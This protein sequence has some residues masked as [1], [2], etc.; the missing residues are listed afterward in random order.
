MEKFKLSD[1]Q[2]EN[3]AGQID[4]VAKTA[5]DLELVPGKGKETIKELKSLKRQLEKLKKETDP[6]IFKYRLEIRREIA[7]KLDAKFVG[8]FH[9]GVAVVEKSD[10][11][12]T[13][14]DMNGEPLVARWG[15]GKFEFPD[16]YDLEVFSKGFGRVKKNK[17]KDVY[18]F[19]FNK[20]GEELVR[21]NNLS[22]VKGDFSDGLIA[23]QKE[24]TNSFIFL[25]KKGEK[26]EFSNSYGNMFFKDVKSF[27]KGLAWVQAE[28]KITGGPLN[29]GKWYLIN[30]NGEKILKEGFSDVQNFSDGVAWVKKRPF[31]ENW[32]IINR[33]GQILS[34]G[35]FKSVREFKGELA[36]V[37]DDDG[38]FFINKQGED[39]Y[40]GA[41]FALIRDFYNDL[42]IISRGH[43]HWCF[44]NKDGKDILNLGFESIEM[45]S[46]DLLVLEM[47]GALSLR[48]KEG[49]NIFPDQYF[50]YIGKLK[51]GLARV[52]GED[53][54]RFIDKD[55]KD[56]FPGKRFDR[57]EDFEDGVAKVK[58]KREYFYID[59]HGNRIFSKEK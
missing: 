25:N 15:N 35:E 3:F 34:S 2:K 38:W 13:Y 56:V 14:V 28:D 44:I 41:R 19:L 24:T 32:Q 4:K 39:I 9:E 54:W 43:D 45:F 59:I 57:I 29:R 47:H 7:E 12:Q 21:K 55:G 16:Y 53:F 11:T 22:H 5:G 46:D 36:R 27:E 42:A 18:K 51:E 48:N 20:N 52:R 49:K 37:E 6:E 26:H 30:K 10:G 8:G 33:Q 1:E 31:G 40:N 23:G 58:K 17:E 50:G